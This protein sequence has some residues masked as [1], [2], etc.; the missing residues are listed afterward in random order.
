MKK[1]SNKLFLEYQ[2]KKQK[3]CDLAE[4][5]LKA[6]W[7]DEKTYEEIL[8]KI[9]Q[10][11]LTIGV[12]G[13]MK[14]GKSTFL[15]S[16]LFGRPFLPAAT[17]PM[18]ATLSVIT[19]GDEEEIVAEF[20]SKDE[21]EQLKDLAQRDENEVADLPT[22]SSI[23][24]AKELYEKSASI[25]SLLPSLLGKTQKDKFE[26]LIEYVGA[27][28][29]YVSIVKSV[30]IYLA[31]DWLK[32]I[33]IVDTPG[34]NDPVVSREERTKEFLKRADVVLMMLYAGRAFDATDRDILFDKVRR[35]GVG[36]VI[37]AVN[38]YDIQLLQNESPEQIKGFVMD[39]IRNAL[40]QYKEDSLSELLNDL[41]PILISAQL[42]LLSKMPLSD[43]RKD[44][45]LKHHYD[46][47]CDDFELS[48]QVQ[49]YELSRVA[50]LE[51][52]VREVISSQKETILIK[53]PINL[54]FQ[55]ANNIIDAIKEELLKLNQSKEILSIPDDELEERIEKLQ[56]AEK[57]IKRKIE[58]AE[59]DL[60]EAFD[61]ISVKLFRDL[62]NKAD[63]VKD[64]CTR[65]IDNY[66]RETL[67][68]KLNDRIERFSDREW[69]RMLED[70]NKKL[71][72]S[73]NDNLNQLSDDIA[74]ILGKY[75][76]D[77]DEITEEFI[78]VLKKGMSDSVHIDGYR[79]ENEAVTT[80]DDSISFGTLIGG[81]LTLPLLPV[82]SFFELF[83]NGRDDA[84]DEISHYFSSIDWDDIENKLS[85]KKDKFLLYLGGDNAKRLIEDLTR[86]A[87]NARGSKEK[88]EKDL[89]DVL[90]KIKLNETK[91][92]N[93]SLEYKKLKALIHYV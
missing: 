53:K 5:A 78:R 12:I 39:E 90:S 67:K 65:I 85:Q 19:Y 77:S 51:N 88:K 18:T 50:E 83:N 10:D 32:G 4:A 14:C 21:W 47:A 93:I 37:L 36:K 3:V 38:K 74:D 29:K 86:Q 6:G 92:E 1:N 91:L 58:Y 80:D 73:L 59:T 68:R 81:M 31:E 16:F 15:N 72:K 43:I 41:E 63:D 46:K 8:A 11:V 69:P 62:Q 61:E 79:S 56:K 48:T 71:Y 30:K 35:V 13:Q 89:E 49:L 34:F 70:L 55:K 75:I 33:E 9:K 26:N 82:I 52:K 87:E 64:E 22:K 7:L 27:D 23:K 17:T 44:L 66:K 2:Q 42:A 25:R 54:I 45:D 24:A 57:R 28:G 20:Y 84:R 40:R 76:D 60:G